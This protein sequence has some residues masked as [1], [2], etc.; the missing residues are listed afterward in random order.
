MDPRRSALLPTV[1]ILNHP[2][3]NHLIPNHLTLNHL[4]LNHP[5]PCHRS[6]GPARQS[7]MIQPQYRNP[8]KPRPWWRYSPNMP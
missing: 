3:L 6:L 1:P 7:R 4:T 8:R 5:F 2:T